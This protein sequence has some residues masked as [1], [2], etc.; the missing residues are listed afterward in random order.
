MPRITAIELENFQAIRKRTVIPIR[1]LTLLFGPNG[2]GKSSVFDALTLLN[3][4]TSDDWGHENKRLL[5][6][7]N[8]WSRNINTKN[9]TNEIGFGIHFFIDEDWSWDNLH[10]IDTFNRLDRA[11]P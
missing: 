5:E 6:L 2:A 1:D 10:H 8:R 11:G 4:I 9:P 3:V 7:L